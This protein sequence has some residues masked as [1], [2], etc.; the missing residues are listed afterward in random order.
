MKRPV[1]FSHKKTVTKKFTK[2]RAYDDPE[3]VK[4]RY[5]FLKNNP[6]CYSCGNPSQAVDHIVAFKGD[7]VKF[8]DVT[9]MI[10]LCHSCHNTITNLF[11]KG[12][13]PNT[14]GKMKWISRK[15]QETE[16][17]V[18]VKVTPKRS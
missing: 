9:N 15:R 10:P 8:W 13:V 2:K 5:V 4:Y 3:W 6:V 14:E 18:K 7:L 1:K 11:D 17:I 16:T 12:P